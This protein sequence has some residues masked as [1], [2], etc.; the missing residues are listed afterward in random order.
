M[1][2]V[3]QPETRVQKV[4]GQTMLSNMAHG[5]MAFLYAGIKN[6]NMM[7]HLLKMKKLF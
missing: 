7:Y 2:D 6:M 3:T 5:N 1:T 4:L